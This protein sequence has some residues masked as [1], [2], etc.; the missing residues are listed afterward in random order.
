MRKFLALSIAMFACSCV[1][2]AQAEEQFEIGS[3]RV[4][5]D[6]IVEIEMMDGSKEC[7]VS[8]P[9]ES[10]SSESSRSEPPRLFVI[11]TQNDPNLVYLQFGL[12]VQDVLFHAKINDAVFPLVPDST[13]TAALLYA[14]DADGEMTPNAWRTADLAF[15]QALENADVLEVPF[16]TKSGKKL[17]DKYSLA[18]FAEA[19]SFSDKAC[20]R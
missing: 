13:L 1:V 18:Q 17:V 14:R 4:F 20:A 3:G 6:W 15:V 16:G 10:Y 19:K 11:N 8:A 5:G 2:N 12:P 9:A 7:A